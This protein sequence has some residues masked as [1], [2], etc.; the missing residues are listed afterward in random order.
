VEKRDLAIKTT[1]KVK[2]THLGDLNQEE[3]EGK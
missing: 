1:T 3:I 2:P